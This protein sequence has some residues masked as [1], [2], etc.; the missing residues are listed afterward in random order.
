MLGFRVIIQ[1]IK[2]TFLQLDSFDKVYGPFCTREKL[3]IEYSA[4]VD[5]FDDELSSGW[6]DENYAV[7]CLPMTEQE[8]TRTLRVIGINPCNPETWNDVHILYYCL[9]DVSR[10]SCLG[11]MKEL[12]L[13]NFTALYYSKLGIEDD[14]IVAITNYFGGECVDSIHVLARHN[15]KIVDKPEN[16]KSIPYKGKYIQLYYERIDNNEKNK[17]VTETL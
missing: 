4:Y 14:I 5:E 16:E 10:V 6:G 7:L 17:I 13:F 3:L 9:M 2:R 8:L 11:A 15:F 1:N 12:Y